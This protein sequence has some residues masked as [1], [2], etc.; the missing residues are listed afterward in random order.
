MYASSMLCL[1]N[2]F[3]KLFTT[4]TLNNLSAPSSAMIPE[5]WGERCHVNTL[6]RVGNST[7][8]Y[9]LCIEQLSVSVFSSTAMKSVSNITNDR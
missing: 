1:Q 8:F 9:L 3:L 2:C 6:F 7:T 5:P 4:L